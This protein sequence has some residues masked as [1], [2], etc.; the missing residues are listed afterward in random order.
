MREV[1]RAGWEGFRFELGEGF[2]I[3]TGM[4]TRSTREKW[5]SGLAAALLVA[6]L[7]GLGRIY[8]K[9]D[10]VSHVGRVASGLLLAAVFL[11]AC[12]VLWRAVTGTR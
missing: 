8:L 4:A 11:V 1:L 9:S 7:A 2:G 3:E 12:L 6:G 5:G 10:L